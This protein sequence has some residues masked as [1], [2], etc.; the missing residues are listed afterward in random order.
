MTALTYVEDIEA[1]ARF[2]LG[3]HEMVLDE[4]HDFSA[5]WD[6]GMMR[7]EG[8]A[9]GLGEA[10]QPIASGM[11]SI[12]VQQRLAFLG[13][14]HEWAIVAGRR[15]REVVFDAPV[16]A[17]MTLRGELI[18]DEI[19]PRSARTGIVVFTVV[20]RNGD[21]TVLRVVHEAIVLRRPDA[22]A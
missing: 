16:R 21:E 9:G 13:V 18:V 8:E 10:G 19:L 3:E 2:A 4:V 20:L 11:H 12:A 6:P 15:L 14:L 17:R 5:R 1:G 22:E 7:V